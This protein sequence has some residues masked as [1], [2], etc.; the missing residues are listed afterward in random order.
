MSTVT[1]MFT[2]H[3]LR[4]AALAVR[5]DRAWGRL[6]KARRRKDR[7]EAILKP[8]HYLAIVDCE[9]RLIA[10]VDEWQRAK[11]PKIQ[12]PAPRGRRG[13]GGAK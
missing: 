2:T 5:V 12:A 1:P 11:R 10:A 6:E 7:A 9:H 8:H 4:A 13:K 3:G